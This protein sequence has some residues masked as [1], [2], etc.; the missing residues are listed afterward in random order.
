MICAP[1]LWAH[2]R[3]YCYSCVAVREPILLTTFPNRPYYSRDSALE[4]HVI[5]R[6]LNAKMSISDKPW[7]CLGLN[8]HLSFLEQK[9]VLHYGHICDEFEKY[10]IVK[11]LFPL[12][13][14][15][16]LA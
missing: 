3:G 7:E 10:R 2:V 11:S 14:C 4:P 12:G 1:S 6:C 16:H 5:K 8:T 15:H 13:L 9:A